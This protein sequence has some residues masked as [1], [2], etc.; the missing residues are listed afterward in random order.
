MSAPSTSPLVTIALPVFNGGRNLRL[1]V[2]SILNQT[3]ADWELLIIDDGSTDD[4][5]ATLPQPLDPRI[6]ILSDGRNKGLAT[7]LNEA[8]GLARG[9]LFARMDHDDVAHQ[10]RLQRQVAFLRSHPEVDLL[11]AKCVTMSE[12]EK[13]VG[14]LPSSVTHAEVCRRPWLG[15]YLA[16]PTWMGRIDWFRR[17]RYA[18][19]GPYCCEDQEL[20]LRAYAESR[21]H[22]LPDALLAY[23]V[24]NKPRLGKLLKTRWALFRV[25][26]KH[27]IGRGQV[28]A[29]IWASLAF[30]VRVGGDVFR[31]LV[32]AQRLMAGRADAPSAKLRDWNGLIASTRDRADAGAS[33]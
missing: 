23:R 16:H 14:E 27:F 1:A 17:H 6:R 22:A 20:L 11:G 21:Y 10:E 8:I 13:I 7:R 33:R 15:F 32:P 2:Q 26:W 19:P 30:A 9:S 25:Q 29:A 18:E 28:G 12:D 4:A 3:F 31:E 24:R 5:L